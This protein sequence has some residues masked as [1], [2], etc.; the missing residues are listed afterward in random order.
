MDA[1]SV[2]RS[3]RW[4]G[5]MASN[6]Q[7]EIA[8][9]RARLRELDAER[10]AL[11]EQ[12]ERWESQSSLDAGCDFTG[13]LVTSGSTAAEKIALF[14]RLFAGRLDV[15]P[16]RWENRN[17]GKS[18]Y[19]LACANE[20]VRGICGK[21]QI[22]CGECPNQ[23][24]IAVSD[25]V[26]ASHLRGADQGRPGG[27]EFVAGVYPILLDETCWFLTAD[28]DGDEWSTDALA[29]ME[30]CRLKSVPAALERSRSG[31]GGHAWI[32]FSQAIPARDARQLGAALL[33]ETLERR[34]E[35]G[36]GSYDR[37]FPSQDTLPQGGF[38]NL[39]ALPL[40]RRAREYGNTVFVNNNL[41]PYQDQ[42]AF[43]ASLPRLNPR[44]LSNLISEAEAGDRVISVRMPVADD[45]GDQPWR[46]SPSRKRSSDRVTELLPARVKIVWSDDIYIDRTAL[47][48]SMVA[49][50]IRL[51]AFQNPEFYRAQ[52]MRLPTYGKPRIISCASLHKNH[53]ALPRGCV[54]EALEL[55][56][57]H[58]VETDVEDL[59]E[60][61]ASLDC[62]FLGTLRDEQQISVNALSKHD[63][64]VL[65]A[66][67]AFGK[68][69]VAAALIAH[70]R[71]STLVLVHRKELLKQWV[72]RLRQFLS[73]GA[74][75]IGVIG[76]G[77]RKPTGRIDVA[78]IQ[79][80]VRRGEASDQ[81]AGYGHLIVDECHH[82]SAS[83]F[84]LVARRSKSRYVLGLSATVTRK[85]GHHPI[86]F[87]QCGPV[88]HRVDPKSQAMRRGFHHKARIRDTEFKLPPEMERSPISM[89]GIY[90][91]LGDDE[92]RNSM[93]FDD[94]LMALEAGRCPL[95][96]TERRDHLET[97]RL[98]F[99]KFTRNL[100]VLHGGLAAGQLR[101][102][103]AG[104]QSGGNAE[105]LVL[106]TGRYLGEGF[107]DSRLDTLFLVMP[108]SWAGT[109]AQYVGRLHREH[110]G[111][112][113]VIV[114]DYVDRA[115]PVLARMAAKREKGYKALGYVLES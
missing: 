32:F 33:T 105:R 90:R 8:E 23:A 51:A 36:F 111:K 1:Q 59:R 4:P 82:L 30:T 29:Y 17:T 2:D 3:V 18:G 92:V 5:D 89:P 14:R 74:D 99:E 104:L 41:I 86:I 81:I 58:D 75:D 48:S 94:V 96:L 98:R 53:V 72:E 83:S 87:M 71:V 65:A 12:L 97:L 42:W 67:T 106:A 40:Q 100:V 91:A 49:R 22:K 20:W 85:D 10:D 43:L 110:H 27:T 57:S 73:V 114:Y 77:R 66:T 93:I 88:R 61:G 54:E 60:P 13:T 26:I 101:A 63:C 103:Q 31:K 7:T 80:L 64:G 45:S 38:G 47:P 112:R 21:P 84:E 68:T 109:L 69:V 28:F 79:S 9:I 24:F 56:R 16:L 115:V 107:D 95:I 46:Q 52:A 78:L 102:A 70:R 50:L 55:L 37:L 44:S 35:L 39:I 6:S 11:T 108:I 15:F 62:R 19:A 34:P 25:N 113:E 76:G